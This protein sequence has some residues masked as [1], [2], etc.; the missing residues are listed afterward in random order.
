MRSRPTL[1][2]DAY[3]ALA[4]QEVGVSDWIHIDQARIDAFA[5]VTM[6][7]QFIHVDPERARSSV[8]GT[9]IAHGFLT[10]SLLSCMAL[11][12]LPGIEATTAAINYG[13]NS[14]RFVAPVKCGGR[15]RGRFRLAGFEERT[16]ARFQLTHDVTV[17][18]E[19]SAKP[20]L[21]A[22]WVSLILLG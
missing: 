21:V 17:E 14:L 9:T 16:H 2:V 13:M 12:A 5:E 18:I 1:S 3:R 20:A 10:L 11:Q 19:N 15:I 8:L 6:D 7:H 4:G 22:Q